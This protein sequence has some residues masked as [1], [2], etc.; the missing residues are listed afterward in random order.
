MLV[1]QNAYIHLHDGWFFTDL[2]LLLLCIDLISFILDTKYQRI[3]H[4]RRLDGFLKSLLFLPMKM[5]L[6]SSGLPQI[7]RWFFS[8][9]TIVYL[10]LLPGVWHVSSTFIIFAGADDFPSEWKWVQQWSGYKGI[11]SNL[12]KIICLH[13]F[14]HIIYFLSF[15]QM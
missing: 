15:S 6:S 4:F 3:G 14:Q 1:M 2:L 13:V 8:C 10:I 12:K 11:P 7:K 9:N 5:S